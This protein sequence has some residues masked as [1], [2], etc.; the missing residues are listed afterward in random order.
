MKIE[1]PAN[2]L[3]AALDLL[4]KGI[5]AA[6]KGRKLTIPAL[7]AARL[8]ANDELRAIA[9][10]GDF[11]ITSATSVTV[12][13]PGEVA[14]PCAALAGIAAKLPKDADVEIRSDEHSCIVQSGRSRYRLPVI[15]IQDMPLPLVIQNPLGTVTLDGAQAL[16]MFE[17]VEFSI[18]REA[19]RF[20]LNGAFLHDQD[21]CLIAVATDGHRLAQVRS[22][23]ESILSADRRL[24]VPLTTV[25]LL[26]KL[27]KKTKPDSVTLTRSDRLIAVETPGFHL[28]SRLIDADYPDYARLLPP[29]DDSTARATLDRGELVKAVERLTAIA[30]TLDRAARAVALQWD[31]AG[32]QIRLAV[33]EVAIDVLDADIIGDAHGAFRLGLTYF[34][35]VL[36]AFAGKH[37][38]LC[39]NGNGEP[40]VVSDPSEDGFLALQM[41]ITT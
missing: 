11:Q 1:A 18:A 25:E 36:D 39:H 29:M 9:H 15:P 32:D 21:G 16:R 38:R 40:V 6:G 37:I 13:G 27:F 34:S 3:A 5:E 19:T 41:P 23:T 10:V 22:T 17:R 31:G 20:Y 24:I 35:E 2:V 26:I 8:T 14:V 30:A 12:N 33:S 7:W 4:D 28:V